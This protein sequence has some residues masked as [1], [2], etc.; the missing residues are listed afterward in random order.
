MPTP[1]TYKAAIRLA[2]YRAHQTLLPV[3]SCAFASP[4]VRVVAVTPLRV[5][6]PIGERRRG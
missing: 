3:Q 4:G 2:L 6:L 1:L 5:R